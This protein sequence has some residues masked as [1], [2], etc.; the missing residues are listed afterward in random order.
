M[1]AIIAD[2]GRQF[3]VEQGQIIRVD[4]RDVPAGESIIFDRVLAVS[5]SDGVK[6]GQPVVEGASVKAEVLGE[7]K[8]EK[9]VVQKLRRRKTLR[10]KTGHRQTY[11]RVMIQ[12]IVA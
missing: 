4:F 1:Y 12:E 10:R 9:L 6:L 11:T 7:Q 2:S 8:G 5:G 3:K